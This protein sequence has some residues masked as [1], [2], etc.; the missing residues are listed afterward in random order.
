MT[1]THLEYCFHLA[2]CNLSH[3]TRTVTNPFTGKHLVWPVDDGFNAE[4]CS[5]LRELTRSAGFSK[6]E[7]PGEGYELSLST[8]ESLRLRD[9]IEIGR[10]GFAV[11]IVVR[12]LTDD[13]LDLVLSVARAGD[14]ALTSVTGEDVTLVRAS[15]S[16]LVA[17]RWPN[18]AVVGTRDD[19]RQ[20]LEQVIGSRPACAMPVNSLAAESSKPRREQTGERSMNG[21]EAVACCPRF[22]PAPWDDATLVWENRR[23]VKDRVRSFLHIPL[24]FGAVMKRNMAMIKAADACAETDVWLSDETSLWGADVYIAVAKD[25][26]GAMMA[27]ISGTFLSKVFEGPYRN[28]PKWIEQMKSHVH[29]K[30]QALDKL[31]FFYTT[32]PRCAKTYGKNY[33]VLLGQVEGEGTRPF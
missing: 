29:A 15:T 12:S 18:A 6:S 32:C 30:G 1:L 21:N 14:C 8:D 28:V 9:E 26:P 13:L 11:E 24:N 31:Y 20:W 3:R 19:L 22:D 23:F 16:E 27:T 5:A 2:T 33:V 17:E 4:Q 25:V 10:T 7:I